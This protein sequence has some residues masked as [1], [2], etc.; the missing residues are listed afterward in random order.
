M[1]LIKTEQVKEPM[2][3]FDFRSIQEWGLETQ[4]KMRVPGSSMAPGAVAS[5]GEV[6][7]FASALI[8]ANDAASSN[9]GCVSFS[10]PSTW[11]RGDIKVSVTYTTDTSGG[12]YYVQALMRAAGDG[13]TV[14]SGG[15]S[16]WETLPAVSS[17]W[18]IATHTFGIERSVTA[19][20]SV[21]TLRIRRDGGDAADTST[22]DLYVMEVTL[23]YESDR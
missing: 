4:A 7:G 15:V 18:E 16:A 5:S 17:A 9:R 21:G 3:Y 14:N 1:W 19:S 6:G 12:D 10:I 8:L 13:D 23:I 2:N 11:N 20:D 22:A